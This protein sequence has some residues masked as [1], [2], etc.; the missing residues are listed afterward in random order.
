MIE[1]RY[2]DI[3]ETVYTTELGNG[4][5]VFVTPRPGFSKSY[6][7]F[8]T[9]YGGADQRF[10]LDGEWIDSPAGVAH[11]LE[12]KMFDTPDGGNALNTLSMNGASP[13]AFTGS[14]MTAYYFSCTENFTDNLRTLLSFV[15]VP[16]FTEESVQKEQGIIGQ[17]IRMGDDEAGN[18]VYYGLLGALYDHHPVREEIAGT[19][20]S[21]A[22]ITVDTLYSC[23]KAFYRPSNMVLCVVGDVDPDEVA[24]IAEELLPKERGDAPRSDYGEKEDLLPVTTRFERKMAVSAPQFLIGSKAAWPEDGRER[25]HTILVANLTLNYLVGESSPFFNKLYADGLL[26]RDFG[27]EFSSVAGTATVI[28]GGESQDPEKVLSVLES[29]VKKAVECGFDAERFERCRRAMY[30]AYLQGLENFSSV[31]VNTA[32]CFFD[33]FAFPELLPELERVTMED[34]VRFAGEVLAPERMALAV[35]RPL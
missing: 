9:R 2:P 28:M 22:E 8:A 21:I 30:G 27:F 18:A 5:N 6:A 33:G 19:V 13:N 3:G 1:I 12:H 15:S 25:M 11:F 32:E 35:I 4:L 29:K 17:E 24:A 26:R 31:A 14:G 10:C 7:L 20:E 16:Y 34:C 23:H